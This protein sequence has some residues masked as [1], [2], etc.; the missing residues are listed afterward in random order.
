M[1]ESLYN[2]LQEKW[3]DYLDQEYFPSGFVFTSYEATEEYDDISHD[4]CKKHGYSQKTEEFAFHNQWWDTFADIFYVKLEKEGITI[5]DSK[6]KET[7]D[8][9]Q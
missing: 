1:S 5:Q 6:V 9:T 2:S 4:F 7:K 8:A 3:R